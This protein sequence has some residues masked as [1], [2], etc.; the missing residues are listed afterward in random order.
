MPSEK[1]TPPI[2]AGMLGCICNHTVLTQPGGDW[3]RLV[4][5]TLTLLGPRPEIF[6][7]KDESKEPASRMTRGLSLSISLVC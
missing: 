4:N 2:M 5:A 7:Q 6:C 1:V 3:G